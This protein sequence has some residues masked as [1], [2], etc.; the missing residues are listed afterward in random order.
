M[1]TSAFMNIIITKH[2]G[3]KQ[4]NKLVFANISMMNVS[5]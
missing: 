1:N 5:I 4:I 3:H 2:Y